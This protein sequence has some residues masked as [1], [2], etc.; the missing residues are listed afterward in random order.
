MPDKD[1][2]RGHETQNLMVTYGILI[3]LLL[4]LWVLY[5]GLVADK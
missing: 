2:V 1:T 4:I 3:V 5:T